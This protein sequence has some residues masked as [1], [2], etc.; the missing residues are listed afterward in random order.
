MKY[1][2]N[3][4]TFQRWAVSDN[5]SDLIRANQE[6]WIVQPWIAGRSASLALIAHREYHILGAFEQRIELDRSANMDGVGFV[7]YRGGVGPIENVSCAD[8]QE[9]SESVLMALP[10]RAKGWIGID[11]LI[12]FGTEGPRDWVVIEINPRLTTSYLGYRQ[13]YGPELA[14]RLI[15]V[16][17]MPSEV[18]FQNWNHITFDA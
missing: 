11:F 14:N 1:F 4:D 6:N 15:E 10:E 5:A 8:L 7:R 13:W 3:A 9:F 18:D 16:R 17:A 2:D 12:P